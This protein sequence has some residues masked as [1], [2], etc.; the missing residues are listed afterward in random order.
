MAHKIVG[1][2]AALALLGGCA[3]DIDEMRT[4]QPVGSPFTKALTEEYREIV[5]FEADE[6]YDWIHASYFAEKGLM[7][8]QGEEVPPELVS[9]WSISDPEARQELVT[10]RQRLE[11][12]FDQ[13]ARE[14]FPA[15]A[16]HAQGRYDCWME[17]QHE[18][19][20][21][22][23]IAACRDGFYAAMTELDALLGT[24]A[25]GPSPYT[26]FFAW[27]SDVVSPAGAVAVDNAIAAASKM[28]L[29]EYAVTG[30]TD[31]SGSAA[32]NL[33]LSLRRANSVKAAL[34]ARGVPD[35]NI[36]VAGRG[37]SDLAVPTPD[38]VREQANRRAVILIQ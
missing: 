27:D 36:S 37:E 3:Y 7:A 23:D 2:V 30:Y 20:Q 10:G 38:G 14:K 26:I 15:I 16:A 9:D 28:G 32:Y 25:A 24:P 21:V 5:A 31:T 33:R 11:G 12:V 13:G 6:M 8:A 22:D 35:V 4:V 18:G 29:S 1:A 34:V 17:Q 19:W